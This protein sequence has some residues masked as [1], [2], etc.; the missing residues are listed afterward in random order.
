MTVIRRHWRYLGCATIEEFS[1]YSPVDLSPATQA[2]GTDSKKL[3]QY[4]IDFTL[5]HGCCRFEWLH[6]RADNGVVFE[7]EVLLSSL[8]IDGVTH[9]QCVQHDLTARRNAAA[10]LAKKKK[11]NKALKAAKSNAE[12]LV[13]TKSQF[14]A[15]LS[16]DI[17]T[18]VTE[19]IGFSD[20][21][22]LEKD[23]KKT[24]IY[25]QNINTTS[26]H[27]LAIL[28]DTVDVSKLDVE[29]ITLQLAHFNLAD[30]GTMLHGLFINTAQEK[31]L[32]L[33]IN[34]ENQ[35][36]EV[37]IGDSLRLRQ[38]LINLL[39]NALKF[40]QQGSVT[41]NI[42][43]QQ[44]DANVAQLLFTITY[45]DM[46]INTEQQELLF[47]PFSEVDDGYA[48]IFDDTALGLSISQD[49][50]Q[51]MGGSIKLVNHPSLGSCFSFEL[52]LPLGDL[53]TIEPQI[54]P[55]LT[56]K[57]ESLGGARILLVEDDA[58]T[59]M[60]LTEL[61]QRF[62]A[63]IVLANNGLE[64]LAVL[65]IDRFD[66]VLMD[67]RMPIMDGYQA[68]LAIRKRALYA[69]LPVIA[70]SANVSDEEK[71]LCIATG[72]NDF[73]AKPINK[74]ELLATLKPWLKH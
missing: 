19:I 74:K 48:R 7:T 47:Q 43:L 52:R 5:K 8:V 14:F 46:G 56:L 42:S 41:L 11:K 64:A 3:A 16:Q 30:L 32:T 10:R 26:K 40:T 13:I 61:L 23:P 9:I 50:V 21:A 65:E 69:Q 12:D 72:M 45:A 55:A 60:F 39:G 70:F 4:Y 28:N 54:T 34:I 44:L 22:L 59:Q 37:L 31:G 68:T 49:L 73:V 1:R 71:R 24:E 53:A 15:N 18:P 33:T 51:L 27:L 25:F 17:R 67:L 36:P 35:V 57:P 2:C 6:Q 29:L 20:L 62:G 38:V 58:F 66:I 63:S